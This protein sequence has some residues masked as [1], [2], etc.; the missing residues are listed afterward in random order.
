MY[1]KIIPF[2]LLPFILISCVN[3]SNP[4]VS[5][6]EPDLYEFSRN[7]SSTVSFPG[8][9]A[10]ILMAEELISTMMDFDSA[11]ESQL[12]Q[13]YRNQDA[14]GGDVDPFSNPELNNETK[15][16][17]ESSRLRR[18]FFIKCIGKRSDQERV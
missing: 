16:V 18:L 17:K 11:T 13:M 5:I 1:K 10:R 15:S 2:F 7:G 8:Q 12:L 4:E 9:T 14:S 6:D 3:D